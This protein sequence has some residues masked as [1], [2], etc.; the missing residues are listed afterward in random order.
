MTHTVRDQEKLIN[1]VKRLR[2]QLTGVE[3]QLEAEADCERVLQT[4]AACRGALTSLMAEI[5]EDHI[6]YHVLSPTTE[7]DSDEAMAAEQLIDVL[8]SYLK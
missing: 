3:R 1:R 2:G 6:R 4:L 8:R 7:P 5:L